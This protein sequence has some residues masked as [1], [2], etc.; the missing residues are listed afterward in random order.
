MPPAMT[1]VTLL[2]DE[3]A[4]GTSEGRPFVHK[5]LSHGYK[6]GVGIMTT[7]MRRFQR[8]S[9]SMIMMCLCLLWM[10]VGMG[11][12]AFVAEPERTWSVSVPGSGTLG[13]RS[14]VRGNAIVASNDGSTLYITTDDGTLVLVDTQSQTTN[15]F[16]PSIIEGSVPEC[17]SGVSLHHYHSGA[18]RYAVYVVTDI[19]YSVGVSYGSISASSRLN[20]N[21]LSR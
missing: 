13:G 3:S 14:L 19:P 6:R 1:V 8:I 20:P 11:E 17:R 12:S 9:R 15:T 18:V 2:V 7:K 16:E 5:R 10:V 21:E 4:V